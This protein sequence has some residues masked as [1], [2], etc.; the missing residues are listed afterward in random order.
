MLTGWALNL[1]I[2]LE[3]WIKETQNLQKQLHQKVQN[4]DIKRKYDK[5]IADGEITH[6]NKLF[7]NKDKVIMQ[8]QKKLEYQDSE[9]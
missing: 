2:K 6:L 1:C 9:L 3:N 8:S 4:Q 7:I 5:S